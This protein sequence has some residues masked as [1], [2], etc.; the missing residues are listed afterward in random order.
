MAEEEGKLEF[1]ALM[2]LA[3]QFLLRVPSEGLPLQWD[4]AHSTVS[5]AGG[6]CQITLRSRKN[7]RVPVTMVR[8][9]CC[10]SASPRLCSLHWLMRLKKNGKDGRIFSFSKDAFARYVKRAAAAVG[11]V[12]AERTGTHAFRRGMATDLLASG[13]DG[14]GAVMLAGG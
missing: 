11:V 2:A 14:G 10:F 12:N 4:G 7:S 13:Q 5:L 6:V 3:R 9:C 8:E 1:G